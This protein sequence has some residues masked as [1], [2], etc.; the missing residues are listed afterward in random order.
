MFPLMVDD[1]STGKESCQHFLI[2]PVATDM[3]A[4]ARDRTVG[5][6]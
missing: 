6:I 5:S 4:Q 3:Q 1:M 2:R